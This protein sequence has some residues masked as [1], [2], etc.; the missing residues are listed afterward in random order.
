MS[1]YPD[2]MNWDAYDARY[3]EDKHYEAAAEYVSDYIAHNPSDFI[4]EWVD[5][6]FEDER[7]DE[8]FDLMAAAAKQ[9]AHAYYYKGYFAAKKLPLHDLFIEPFELMVDDRC[10]ELN[11]G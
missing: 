4:T 11:D 10:E 9:W 5:H 1:N 6:D 2:D 3:G 8:Q 7:E